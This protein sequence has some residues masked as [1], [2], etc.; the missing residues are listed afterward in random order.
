MHPTLVTTVKTSF[1]D[2]RM[3]TTSVLKMMCSRKPKRSVYASR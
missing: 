3:L 2:G 1:R